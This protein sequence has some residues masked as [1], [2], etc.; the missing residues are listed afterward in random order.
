[1]QVRLFGLFLLLA[2]VASIGFLF[3][4]TQQLQTVPSASVV[5]HEGTRSRA[6]SP[7]SLPIATASPRP[8]PERGVEPIDPR[9]KAAIAER[10]K[11]PTINSRPD[12]SLLS[13]VKTKVANY[14]FQEFLKVTGLSMKPVFELNDYSLESVDSNTMSFSGSPRDADLQEFRVLT[15]LGGNTA[16]LMRVFLNENALLSARQTIDPQT[17]FVLIETPDFHYAIALKV[18]PEQTAYLVSWRQSKPH[19]P[20]QLRY[21]QQ[22]L[23][24]TSPNS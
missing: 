12:S 21:F 6:T 2:T 11:A 22:V 20:E 7:A 17:L 24:A 16:G 19:T 3:S 8:Q 18:S 10:E 9:E 14:A 23:S 4:K 13:G 5:A 1:M 15:Q